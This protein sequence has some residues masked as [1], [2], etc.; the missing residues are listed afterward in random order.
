MTAARYLR[1][2]DPS[3]PGALRAYNGLAYQDFWI[4]DPFTHGAYSYYKVGQYTTLCGE[5]RIAEN[6]VHFCGEQTSIQWQGYIN[7][8]VE[9]GE[10]AAREIL[11]A[12]PFDSALG[13]QRLVLRSG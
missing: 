4:G 10:R 6:S 8:A 2:L 9:S 11:R 3:L 5:E 12:A 13:A 1:S 7:G